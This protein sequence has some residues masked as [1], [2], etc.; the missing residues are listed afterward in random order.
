MAGQRKP[1]GQLRQALPIGAS[2]PNPVFW[3][4]LQKIHGTVIQR[5]QF[6]HQATAQAKAD[7]QGGGRH[8]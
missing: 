7:K 5:K 8:R 4:A 3:R 2:D 1:F 6:S